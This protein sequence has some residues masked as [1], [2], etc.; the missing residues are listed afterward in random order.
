MTLNRSGLI[1]APCGTPLETIL[2]SEVWLPIL[3]AIERSRRKFDIQPRQFP[4]MLIFESLKRRPLVQ[5]VS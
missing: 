3:M 5:T 2:G 1:T 4:W